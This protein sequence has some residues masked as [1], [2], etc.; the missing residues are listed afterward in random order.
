MR[1]VLCLSLLLAACEPPNVEGF[2]DVRGTTMRFVVDGAFWD[3][4]FPSDHRVRDDSRRVDLS[5][6]PEADVRPVITTLVGMLDDRVQGWSR[7]GAVWIPFEAPLSDAHLPSLDDSVDDPDATVFLVDVDREGGELGRRWPID[8]IVR[9]G[10]GLYT[11]DFGLAALPLQGVPLPANRRMAL[12]AMR[13][14]EDAA[15]EVL[16][17]SRVLDQLV[18]GEVPVGWRDDV[19]FQYADALAALRDLEVPVDDVVGLTVFSTGRPTSGWRNLVDA[20]RSDGLLLTR[21]PKFLGDQ[22]DYCAYEAGFDAPVYQEG[23]APYTTTGGGL[24]LDDGVPVLQRR[25]NG[26]IF[27]SV[28]K[29]EPVSGPR[30]TVVFIRTGGGGDRPLFDRGP[31]AVA[32][33]DTEWTG[34]AGVFARA[35]WASVQIDG[36]LGGPNRNPSG[37]DEQFLIFNVSNPVAMRGN[38]QQSALELALLPDVLQKLV[39]NAGSCPGLGTD[40]SRPIQFAT[41]DLVLF[42]HSMGATIAP[43]VLAAEPRY[44]A[45]ILSGAG[46]SWIENIVHKTKPV[47]TLP[48]ASGLL[49]DEPEDVDVFHP[50]LSLLQWAGEPMDPPLYGHGL[51]RGSPPED[52]RHVL[53]FQGVADHYIPPPVANS[54]SLA[55]G[56]DLVG[57]SLDRTLPQYRALADLLRW[58]PGVVRTPPTG[59]NVLVGE[60]KRTAGVVQVEEDGI[61]DGHEVVFQQGGPKHVIRCFLTGLLDQAPLIAELGTELSPCPLGPGGG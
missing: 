58:S 4:P 38:L 33:Q 60:Q 13:G 32:G 5:G 6:F 57:P 42:G 46:G 24:V 56:L 20:A 50:G 47:P 48:L 7:T 12:V 49:G 23:E 31:R 11:P 52:A 3:A 59:L 14:V 8:V 39:M 28:P 25:E 16:S 55:M 54:L 21:A 29:P 34:L 27:L 19:G 53:M 9:E 61:E 37:A 15:G 41:D 30:P 26:R 51:L 45:T 44:T 35:G 40:P 36:P 22:G 10:G 43:L 1:R 17:P 18:R 2:D